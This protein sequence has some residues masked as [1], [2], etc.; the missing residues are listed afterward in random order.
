MR[1]HLFPLL[2]LLALPHCKSEKDG[3]KSSFNCNDRATSNK[4]TGP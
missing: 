1:H 3:S 2:R 4:Q